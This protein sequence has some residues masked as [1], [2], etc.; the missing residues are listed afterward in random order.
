MSGDLIIIE[1]VQPVGGA[2]VIELVHLPERAGK[3]RQQA[4]HRE[5]VSRCARTL[6]PRHVGAV[7]TLDRCQRRLAAVGAR[8]SAPVV[9]CDI[10]GYLGP[11]E[12]HF[13]APLE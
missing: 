3:E 2:D 4:A 6:K 11:G 1:F 5:I 9:A 7:D 13:P 12:A 10:F 8:K